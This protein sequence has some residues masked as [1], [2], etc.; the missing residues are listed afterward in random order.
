MKKISLLFIFVIVAGI[1]ISSCG[2]KKK[3]V[4]I[5]GLATYKDPATGFAIKY[6]KN[7][8]STNTI[9][10]R[11]FSYTTPD[12]LSRFKTYTAD[13]PAGAKIDFQVI[14]LND[15]LTFDKVMDKKFFQ[16]S[17]YSAPEKVTIDGVEGVKQ[18]YSFPLSDGKVEG[19]IYYAQKDSSLVAVINFETFADLFDH[20]RPKFKEILNSVVL[21][22]IKKAKSDTIKKVVEAA[23]PSNNLVTYSND[24]FSIKIPD[25]FD[26][27]KP[28]AGSFKFEGERRGDC[29]IIIDITDASKQSNLDKIVKDNT[30][31]FGGKAPKPTTLGGVK[32][33]VFHYSPARHMDRKVYFAVKNKKLYRIIVDWNTVED[34]GLFYPIFMKCVQ[35]FKFK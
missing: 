5:D 4:E 21:P 24:G 29:Y 16:K 7:W 34:K 18:T 14:E 11:F 32:A 17:I 12:I 28:K 23:P 8:K 22:E 25:N 26:V 31:K 1:F 30:A 3:V 19:E 35:S 33:Y 20:Y 27:K 9:G 10:T 6:P 15:S 2:E 13:G